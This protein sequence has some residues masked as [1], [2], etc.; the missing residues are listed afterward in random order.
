MI[1]KVKNCKRTVYT[2]NFK[3]KFQSGIRMSSFMLEKYSF[4]FTQ[5]EDELKN[6]ERET[7][8]RKWS[9]LDFYQ[10]FSNIIYEDKDGC[11][12]QA[13]V[14]LRNLKNSDLISVHGGVSYAWGNRTRDLKKAIRSQTE[15]C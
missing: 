9:I 6:W 13:V 4:F 5:K 7:L 8:L 1:Q 10:V 12:S 3:K 11:Y 14:V 15:L 2:L